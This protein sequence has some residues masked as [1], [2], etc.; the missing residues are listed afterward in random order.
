MAME[1]YLFASFVFLNIFAMYFVLF[2]LCFNL[3][4]CKELTAD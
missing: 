1:S 2:E 3:R 4:Q